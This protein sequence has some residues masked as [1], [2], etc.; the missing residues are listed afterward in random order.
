MRSRSRAGMITAKKRRLQFA[1]D[2]WSVGALDL[3]EEGR[4][5]MKDA[6]LVTGGAGFVGSH[7]T[8][9][10]LA[11][12]YRVRVL[13]NFLYGRQGLEDVATHPGLELIEGDICDPSDLA[14]AV[15]DVRGVIALAALVG[16]G[17]CDLHPERSMAINYY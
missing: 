5:S 8:R 9:K 11:R 14:K 3:R 15:R 6:V 10:L 13:D 12:G 1:I 17:A 16:D 4:G 7:L 2:S